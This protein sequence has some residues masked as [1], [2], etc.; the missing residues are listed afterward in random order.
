M[1]QNKFQLIPGFTLFHGDDDR[2]FVTEGLTKLA[3]H[4]FFLVHLG[5]RLNALPP[6]RVL[7][8]DAIKRAN[9]NAVIAPVTKLLDDYGLRHL[10]GTHAGDNIPV[11]VQDALHRAMTPTDVTVDAKARID[12]IELIPTPRDGVGR[13]LDFTN[14]TP[15]TSI[16][17]EVSHLDLPRFYGFIGASAR[18]GTP[19]ARL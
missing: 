17:N 16:C 2:L 9:F 7:E 14:T 19:I 8:A 12:D 6:F 15:N 3:T 10:L 4:T 5:H 1:A 13:T 11:F 18:L